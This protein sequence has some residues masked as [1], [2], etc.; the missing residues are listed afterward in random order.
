[1]R[2]VLL[3][4]RHAHD[5]GVVHRDIKPDNIFLAHK[6]GEEIVKILDF[7]IAK[8][9]AGATE[10][11]SATRSGITVGTPTYLSPEQAVGG[12][13]T[14]ACDLYSTSVV[15]YEM[16]VGRA[17]FEDDSPIA[18][19][20]AHACSEVPAFDDLASQ[21]EIPDGLEKVVRAG[22]EKVAAERIGSAVEYVQRIDQI[23]VANGVEVPAM[24]S[25]VRASQSLS[26]PAGPY[27]S[28]TPVP[29]AFGLATVPGAL[30]PSPD[31]LGTSLVFSAAATPTPVSTTPPRTAPSGAR[32]LRFHGG[33]TDVARVRRDGDGW[34]WCLRARV[35]LARS[36]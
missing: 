24:P 1:V 15:L 7:G 33:H 29:G 27:A 20:T 34:T 36:S 6:D 11:L 9:Y 31:F 26:I 28:A 4:L 32:R 16:L 23:L 35:V 10:E 21:L 14:P 30:S 8:L 12:A 5:R 19:M 17:P 2:G 13:I 22:L 18:L 25:S 3:G